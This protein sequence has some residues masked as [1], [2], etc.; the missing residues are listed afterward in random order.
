MSRLETFVDAAFAFAL[1]LL[2]ISFD[3]IPTSFDELSTALRNMPAFA[4]SFAVVVMV[5][6]GH[7]R[8]SQSYGLDDG[9]STVL[10]F[11]LVL[12]LMTY[13]FPLRAMAAA[14]MHALTDGWTP[15]EF[16]ITDYREVRG[17][18]AIYGGGWAALTGVLALLNW[19][20]LRRAAALKLSSL[21]RSATRYEA[22]AW[23]IV[24]GFGLLSIV[25]SGLLPDAL[26]PIASWSYSGLAIAMPL[27]SRYVRIRL[28]H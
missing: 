27:Y 12:T 5:W 19:H 11:L 6:I 23:T 15:A 17:L 24:A 13:V 14:V 2:V 21:E 20:S 28:R 18:V 3:E 22:L 26:M 4:A 25:L 8:W 9:P 7:R 16:A 10:S 1:T